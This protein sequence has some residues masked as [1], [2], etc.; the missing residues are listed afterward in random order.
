M[1]KNNGNGRINCYRN[2]MEL[3]GQQAKQS[4]LHS[5]NSKIYSKIV[6]KKLLR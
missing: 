5:K 2:I 1:N 4:I 6:F 3:P